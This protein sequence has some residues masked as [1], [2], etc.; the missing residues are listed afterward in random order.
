MGDLHDMADY[1]TGDGRLYEVQIHQGPQARHQTQFE[2][3]RFFHTKGNE[4]KA[5]WEE[6]W[7]TNQHIYRGTDTSPGSG[8]YYTL[9]DP[10]LYGS[11]W[12][13][14]YWR[15][16]D[17][18]ERNPLVTF[19]RKDNCS[20]VTEG[21]QNTYLR[22]EAY[23]EERQFES[24]I[25]LNNVVELAWLLTPDGSPIE[26]YYYAQNYGLVGWWSNDRGF[27]YIS[28][29]HTPGSRPDNVREVIG[30]LDRGSLVDWN[31]AQLLIGPLKPPYRAK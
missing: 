5:E 16:G 31:R 10:G 14:R 30:C 13:P 8:N 21:W 9:R 1:M 25:I 11:A 20:V 15:V 18:F 22:F 6:L 29:I 27:S 28:E 2:D 17:V 4:I 23:F 12:S 26:K 3:V 7:A 19:Y 24:G